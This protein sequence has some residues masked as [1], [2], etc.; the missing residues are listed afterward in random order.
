MNAF[1]HP[2][3]EEEPLAD[4]FIGQPGSRQL[5]SGPPTGLDFQITNA[6]FCRFTADDTIAEQW[7]SS[8]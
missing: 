5:W 8:T 7:A 3:G 6:D 2:S 1:A 4:L